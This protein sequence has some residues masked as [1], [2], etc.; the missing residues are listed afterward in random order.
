VR[1]D[2]ALFDGEG[3]MIHA[4]NTLITFIHFMSLF[5][6]ASINY[7]THERI[8]HH[9][10]CPSGKSENRQ[11]PGLLFAFKALAVFPNTVLLTDPS[12]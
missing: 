8:F 1:E 6:F 7:E 3:T 4:T 5:Y 2:E 11:T 10:H 12:Y 9:L